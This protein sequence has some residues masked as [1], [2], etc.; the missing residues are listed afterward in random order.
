MD[1]K[2]ELKDILHLYLE[3]KV[4]IKNRFTESPDVTLKGLYLK[5]TDGDC[6]R[7]LLWTN[8]GNNIIWLDVDDIQLI[9]RPLSDMNIEEKKE[10]RAISNNE[11]TPTISQMAQEIKWFLSKGFDLFKLIPNGYAIDKNSLV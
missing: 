6:F 10:W 11:Q 8:P 1:N 2:T 5:Q 4:K 3:Q 7:V 9:L